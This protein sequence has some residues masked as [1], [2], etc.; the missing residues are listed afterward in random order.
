[1]TKI[2]IST[3]RTNQNVMKKIKG[4]CAVCGENMS[5]RITDNL[6]HYS[7][8]HYFGKMRIPIRGMGKYKKVGRSTLFG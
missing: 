1:M 6:G 2:R 4:N 8:G 3:E 5:I 7:N